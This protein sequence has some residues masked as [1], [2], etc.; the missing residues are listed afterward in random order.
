M[1]IPQFIEEINKHLVIRS[2]HSRA[3]VHSEL[4]KMNF[5]EAVLSNIDYLSIPFFKFDAYREHYE[6]IGKDN[7]YHPIP[8][9]FDDFA[10]AYIAAE[11]GF[12][13]V[14]YDHHLL[15]QITAYLDYDCYWPQDIDK[16]P[17]D[18]MILLDTNI[19]VHLIEEK[20][21]AQKNE[22]MAMFEKNKSITFLLTDHVFEELCSVYEKKFQKEEVCEDE[23]ELKKFIDDFD[24][25]DS[26]HKRR[27]LMKKRKRNEKTKKKPVNVCSR[28]RNVGF[29]KDH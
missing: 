18:S 15:S 7:P 1:T 3:K 28:Y 20:K 9:S 17:A 10:L 2:L 24:G 4:L 11:N 27:I 16:L 21:S 13:L 8:F 22:I 6:F 19:F 25:F 29:H 23:D 5:K 12:G 26:N 14:S